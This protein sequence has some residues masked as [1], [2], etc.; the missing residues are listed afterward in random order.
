[1]PNTKNTELVQNLREK[2]RKAKSLTFIDYLGLNVNDIN[3]FRAKMRELGAETEVTKNTLVL[4]ALKEESVDTS[5]MEQHLKGPTAT[6]FSYEDPVSHLKTVYEFA[7]KLELPQIKF[8][9]IEGNYTTAVQTET[10]SELPS[11]EDLIAKIVGGLKS[12]LSGF[13]N[14]LGGTNRQFVTVLSKIAESKANAGGS[15]TQQ[16]DN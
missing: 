14:V 1:M 4:L 16:I 9:Y 2:V 8:A 5:E 13:V 7:K 6:I 15:P 10:I 12:P 11:R 3:D